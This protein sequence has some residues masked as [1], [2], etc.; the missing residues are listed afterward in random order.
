MASFTRAG[1]LW[2]ALE[3]VA[4]RDTEGDTGVDGLLHGRVQG[5]VHAT[6][7]RHVGD[8]GAL[9]VLGDPVD[10]RDDLLGGAGP[11]AVEDLDGDDLGLLGDTVLGTADGARDMRAVA[12]VVLGLVALVD[13]VEAVRWATAEVLVADVDAGVDDVG[14]DALTRGVRV[15]VLLVSLG[16]RLV[17]TVQAPRR[18]VVLGLVD[19]ELLVLY[20]LVDGRVGGEL[21]GLFRTQTGR[22]EA[23]DGGAETPLD[24]AAV[25]GGQVTALGGTHRLLQHDDVAAVH[26]TLGLGSVNLAFGGRRRTRGDRGD[27]GDT[28]GGDR[29]GYCRDEPLLAGTLVSHCEDSPRSWCGGKA[30]RNSP[31]R[32]K[33][34]VGLVRNPV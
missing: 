10:A 16:V 13:G 18:R 11:L 14:G 20:D 17:D 27:R 26:G 3:L 34:C 33:I 2:P 23:V 9:V 21:P 12:V 30:L 28:G 4:R 25:L 31:N 19:V 5:L 24:L 15:V 8:R 1:E 32:P 29:G 22:R 7:E 6:A